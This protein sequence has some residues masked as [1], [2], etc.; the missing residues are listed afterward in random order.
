MADSKKITELPDATTPIAGTELLEI[1]QGGINKKVA[2]SEVGGGVGDL[3]LDAL[4]V[5]R[6]LTVDH[7]LDATDLASINAGD[8]LVIE[9]NQAI[10]NDVTVP[11]NATQAFPVGSSMIVMQI[12]IGLTSII[13]DV[14]VTITSS[15]GHLNSPGQYSP[16]ILIKKATNT[17]Y[18]FNGLPSSVAAV[19]DFSSSL[20]PVGFSA[21]AVQRGYYSDDGQIV[22]MTVEISGTSNSTAFTFSLPIALD[23]LYTANGF[24]E[25]LFIQN[26][27]AG[28]AGRYFASGGG[29]LVTVNATVVGGNFTNS[30]TKACKLSMFWFK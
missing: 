28:A 23:A 22:H 5:Y 10:A 13:A 9:E 20:T 30:G 24:M 15:A 27:G 18:L 4:S 17:W 3:K 21:V 16:M 2:A 29:T 19:Q 11:A 8:S 14:G 26:V 6:T 7:I 12:G 25:L 1:V